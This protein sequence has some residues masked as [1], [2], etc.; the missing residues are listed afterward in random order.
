MKKSLLILVMILA[1]A[2]SL[3]AAIGWSGNIWP[4]SYTDHTN[5]LDI[6]VYYQ[7]W[8]DGVTSLPGQGDS[9]SATIYYKTQSQTSYTSELMTFNVDIGDNDEYYGVIPNSIFN[10]GDTI[11]F[12]CEGYDSTDG[13]FSYG[14]DQNGAG[15][16]D[17]NNPGE[18]Y[19]IAGLNQDVTVTFQVDMSVVGPIEPV[20][21]AGSF[22][23]WSP[24]IDVLTN[25]GNDLYAGDI[26][27]AAGTNPSQEYKFVNG[28]N[29]E[30]LIGNRTLTIDDS[31]P[32]M[33]L[34]PV[35]FNDIPPDEIHVTFQVDMSV[36]IFNGWFV[37]DVDTSSVS[38]S[39]NNWSK[40]EL[41]DVDADE[42]YTGEYSFYGS[43]SD[44][45]EYK[46]RINDNFELYGL[47]NRN[48][49]I[50]DT[51]TTIPVV[52]YDDFN[53]NPPTN[54]TATVNGTDVDLDWDAPATRDVNYY[55][56]YRD[57]SVFALV[58][59]PTTSFTDTSVPLGSHIYYATAFYSEGESLPSNT[60]SVFIGP[61]T[62][63]VA[64]AGVDQVMIEEDIVYLDGSGSYDPDGLPLTYLW[65]APAGIELSDSTAVDPTFI[66]PQV[67]EDTEY[68]F[69]LI[70]FDGVLYSD[71]DEVVI[72]VLNIVLP[73]ADFEAFPTT[74][75]IPLEVTFNDESYPD[76]ISWEWDFGDNETSVLQDPIHTY[77]TAGTFSVSLTVTNIFG[78]DTITKVDYIHVT[79]VPL[80]PPTNLIYAVNVNDVMLDW[81]AP[82][83]DTRNVI[84][85]KVYR[86]YEVI[87]VVY[88]PTTAYAD[89][90][91]PLGEYDYFVTAMYPE[92]ESGP[93][94]M[95]TVNIINNPPVADA[96]PDQTVNEGVFVQLDGSGSYDPEGL[97]L[98]YLWTAPVEVTLNDPTIVDPSFTAP[99]VT[100]DEVFPI[101]LMVYDG[102]SWSAPDTVFITVIELM[103][104]GD[105]QH[106]Y[107]TALHASYP[108]PFNSSTTISFSLK[109]NSHV[110][111]VIYN[112]K[113]ERVSTIMNESRDSG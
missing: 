110:E 45:I 41:I 79:S 8:K 75:S 44:V 37:P 59:S 40:W 51:I 46:F 106:S 1:L 89:M 91:L 31:S 95:I 29:W 72:T 7:I 10:T 107:E 5:G 23:G 88:V 58:Y 82:S 112:V 49:T 100:Q 65:S 26:L 94:N 52:Y 97:P 109:D 61:N 77:E 74:G 20:S 105:E 54:L 57:D 19:I 78:T 27:F 55:N 60:Q 67:D 108:N 28:G 13:T 3:H 50:D 53:P 56:L 66:A 15:P 80:N 21:A 16:F 62:P 38:G 17:V 84:Y 11:F 93:T 43:V 64:D 68:I 30:D 76:I 4:N 86:N 83:S 104:T 18:Y 48:F 73:I 63:P 12:Y 70:V 6:T 96:G 9:I 22:N 90:N 92:G 47:P 98:T 102:D 69:S 111:I 32:T 87:A 24:G 2:G 113:G 71:P 33:V 99:Q 36:Q 85:Y 39:M 101:E 25:Q 42:I 35:Y 81:D 103:D 34:P 14:T